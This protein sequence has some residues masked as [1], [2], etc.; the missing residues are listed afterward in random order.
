VIGVDHQQ[1]MLDQFRDAAAAQAVH[2]RTVLG[3]WPDVAT[4]TPAADVVVCHHVV[5]NVV[6]IGPFVRSLH[7]H[8]GASVVVEMTATHPQSSLAALWRHFWDLDRPTEPTADSFVDVV[9]HLGHEP[10]V[11][12]WN[13]P[14]RS[15]PLT[16]P[17][18][19]A[20]LRQRLCLTDHHDTEIDGLLGTSPLLAADEVVTVS[21]RVQQR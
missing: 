21:W 16:R 4:H 5:Y 3:S 11:H 6:D 1:A 13:R 9:R 17:Q 15:A 7:D 8:A 18:L 10:A 20:N 19:V 2:V 12:R 14:Q